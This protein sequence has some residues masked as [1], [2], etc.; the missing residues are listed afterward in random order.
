MFKNKT[1]MLKFDDTDSDCYICKMKE[2]EGRQFELVS[3]ILKQL[4]YFISD[5]LLFIPKP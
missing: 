4:G 3:P 1:G 2:F 5:F